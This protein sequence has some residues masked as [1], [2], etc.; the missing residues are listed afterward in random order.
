MKNTI[1]EKILIG[2]ILLPL[3]YLMGY[4]FPE[5]M[6]ALNI[7]PLTFQQGGYILLLFLLLKFGT[8]WLKTK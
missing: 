5:I 3:V 1:F 6:T 2:L 8:N 4:I 7:Q